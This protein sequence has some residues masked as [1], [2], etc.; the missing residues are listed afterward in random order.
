M[1]ACVREREIFTYIYI[2]TV[3]RAIWH[4]HVRG[5]V[6]NIMCGC[7]S[8]FGPRL[9]RP[10]WAAM[11]FKLPQLK[12]PFV[13]NG[14]LDI[15]EF[16]DEIESFLSQPTPYGPLVQTRSLAR[17]ANGEHFKWHHTNPFALMWTMCKINPRFANFMK[18]CY[19]RASCTLRK[20]ALYSDE[21]T[22]GNQLRP[23]NARQLQAIYFALLFFPP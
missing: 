23:D 12:F 22:P 5:H 21:T 15:E 2:H 3:S 17:E 9:L 8:H 13:V 1:R 4:G 20:V 7:R 11:C 19:D 16:D 18:G 10:R 14:T 6:C